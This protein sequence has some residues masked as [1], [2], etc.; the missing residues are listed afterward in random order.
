MP[1]LQSRSQR[2]FKL[3]FHRV[4]GHGQ[5]GTVLKMICQFRLR[6]RGGNVVAR[7]PPLLLLQNINTVGQ[8]LQINM[9]SLRDA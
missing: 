8:C 5:C 1:Q 4:G 9:I 6:H 3:R 7:R 2:L